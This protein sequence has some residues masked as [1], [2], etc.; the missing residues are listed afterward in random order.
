MDP[1]ALQGPQQPPRPAGPSI[2]GRMT[3]LFALSAANPHMLLGTV[4]TGR[5]E[6]GGCTCGKSPGTT[7]CSCT[8]GWR[9]MPARA[10]SFQRSPALYGD[11]VASQ[12]FNYLLSQFRQP[13]LGI[14][15]TDH[16]KD[17]D[18]HLRRAMETAPPIRNTPTGKLQERR[19]L[20]L[21]LR[22]K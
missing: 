3:F 8:D 7:R 15:A 6:T 1:R 21:R 10:P 20:F 5:H 4:E 16:S 11:S 18:D 22:R 14:H 19:P 13:D 17:C 9:G 12:L 2:A